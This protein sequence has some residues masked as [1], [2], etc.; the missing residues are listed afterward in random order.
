[1]DYFYHWCP[2]FNHSHDI[3]LY[4]FYYLGVH[5]SGQIMI[6]FL[7]ILCLISFLA[8]AMLSYSAGITE[9]RLE[10]YDFWA[11]VFEHT[12]TSEWEVFETC[13]KNLSSR[14]AVGVQQVINNRQSYAN[15]PTD[16]VGSYDNLKEGIKCHFCAHFD[17]CLKSMD[18]TSLM[19]LGCITNKYQF[20]E[21]D[22]RKMYE[23]DS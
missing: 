8:G 3:V 23:P 20:F 16:P 9:G 17:N 14:G 21:L 22:K 4:N 19:P 6:L 15:S 12:G 13:K 1:M 5:Q 7:S 10:E 11:D 18:S 2:Y